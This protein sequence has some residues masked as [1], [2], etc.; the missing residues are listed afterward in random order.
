MKLSFSD[1]RLPATAI[2]L[3]AV[4]VVIVAEFMLRPVQTAIDANPPDAA[5]QRPKVV[6]FRDAARA[7]NV[8]LRLP[9]WPKTPAE[10]AA[11]MDKATDESTR[12]LDEIAQ[13]KP[14]QAS[15]RNT[16]QAY[17]LAF[18][19]A[20]D[21]DG[22]VSVIAQA[23]P[24]KAMRDAGREADKRFSS[25]AVSMQFREDI[26][27]VIKRFSDTEPPLGDADA[28]LLRDTMRDYRRNG[29]HLSGEQRDEL[30]TLKTE[31]NEF[32]IEFG[33]NITEADLYL[34][35]S[36]EQLAG[37]P[38]DFLTDESLRTEDS[39]YRINANV[40]W[41][42][43]TI[44]ENV[45]DA[46]V[47]KQ[48]AAARFQRAV[49]SNMPLLGKMLAHRAR[50]A[51][52]LGYDTW[53]DYRTETRMAKDAATAIRFQDQLKE[54]LDSKFSEE[55]DVLRDLKRTQTGEAK[56]QLDYW[57]VQYYE[58]Q[59]K[60]SRYN[61]DTEQLKVYF[62]MNRTLDGMFRIFEQL[63]DIRITR[64]DPPF[65]WV[66]GL[67]LYVIS[68]ASSSTPLGMLY[69]DLYPRKGKYNHFAHFGITAGKR[70]ADGRMQRP[71]S[72]LICNFPPATA[73]K[74]SL[75]SFED[76]QTLF[77]EFGHA[78]HN[79]LSTASYA[80]QSGTSVPRDFVEAPSQM[81]EYWVRDKAVL[82]R[83]AA[84]YRDPD[85]KIPAEVLN[86]LD[87]ARRATAAIFE[88]GQLAYSLMDM[89][90]H[91]MKTSK[92]WRD[93]VKF[94]NSIATEIYMKYPEKTAMIASFGHLAGYDAGYYGY[95]W[96][97]AIAEDMASVFRD[98][99]DGF[100]DKTIGRRMRDEIYAPGSSRDVEGSIQAFLGRERSLQPFFESIGIPQD[101]KSQTGKP[102]A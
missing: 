97:R 56:A 31:L 21:A 53:A 41:Q 13:I 100:M 34:E 99:A 94:S 86:A 42:R 67:H 65:Q 14:Y 61:I 72:A 28:I 91:M 38:Q 39:H 74:P 18:Y 63:F 98:S 5:T 27:Q 11:V 58:N 20:M 3:L 51:K 1:K 9:E 96:S 43:N 36:A 33:K 73:D 102:N 29:M 17:E 7:A 12:L 19:P 68:D 25:W 35:F 71:V 48:V 22:V 87:E 26:Y 88:R 6:N 83:F 92:P 77:H 82:D 64:V 46:G 23:H 90:L 62:E 2:V 37:A 60:K 81:L 93:L 66:E 30:K 8:V 47:R 78:M 49:D 84:D 59:L 55:L 16:V 15:F 80:S 52:I 40:T 50:I 45:A 89:R 54:G 44:L 79:M 76:V 75:L 24:D 95:A 85:R 69:M 4:V 10:V 70:L 32:E 101:A 57:D